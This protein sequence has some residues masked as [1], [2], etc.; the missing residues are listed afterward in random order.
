MLVELDP[1]LGRTEPDPE[2]QDLIGA[3]AGATGL[4]DDPAEMLERLFGA[5]VL[6]LGSYED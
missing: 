5:L 2:I 6:P 4:C 1:A 3:S